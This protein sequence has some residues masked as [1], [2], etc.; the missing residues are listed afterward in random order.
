MSQ[1]QATSPRLPKGVSMLPRARSG[2]RFLAKIRR[3]G[4]EVHLGLYESAGLAAFAFNV[5]SEAMGRGSR[6][7]NEIPRAEQPDAEEVRRITSN[8]R[9]RLGLDPPAR[10]FDEIPPD[11]EALLTLFEVTIVGFWRD[12]AA[13]SEPGPGL[14][15]AAR[16][17]AESARLVFWNPRAGHP[18]PTEAITRLVSRRI[19]QT[20]RRSD[21][22]RAILD[23]DGDDDWRVA[24]WLV[25]PDAFPATRGF[26]DEVRF[27]YSDFFEGTVEGS[28]R[29]GIPPW[30]TVLGIAPPFSTERVRDAY[31]ARSKSAHPDAGGTHVEFVRLREAFEEARDYCQALG[32]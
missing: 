26:R 5:A 6:P 19:D 25:H 20:F 13:Q 29:A 23:D 10:P 12:Q 2:R 4:I 22:T 15:A 18:S 8:V 24:R 7:P 17:L 27:L 11:P 31:R 32:I 30:A 16:R 21:L 3:K 14:D 28:S 9:K 1:D